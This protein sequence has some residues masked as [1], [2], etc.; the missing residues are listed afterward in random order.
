MIR[1]SSII[2]LS[3]LASA[4]ALCTFAQQ[5]AVLA[6]PPPTEAVAAPSNT[7]PDAPSAALQDPPPPNQPANQNQDYEGKQTK[8]IL[9]IIPNFRSG[10]NSLMRLENPS[11]PTCVT[12][13]WPVFV[14]VRSSLG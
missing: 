2:F 10:Q 9:G 11:R 3:L 12:Q 13:R 7:L 8:R 6:T 4:S 5:G 1:S 14:H